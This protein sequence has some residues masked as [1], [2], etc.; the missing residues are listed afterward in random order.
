[1]YSV[2]TTLFQ[3]CNQCNSCPFN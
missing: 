1:M 2:I 3:Q